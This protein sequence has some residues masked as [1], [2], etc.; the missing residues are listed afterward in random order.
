MRHMAV[1]KKAK[2]DRN[3]NASNWLFSQTTGVEILHAWS[4]QT[5]LTWGCSNINYP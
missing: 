4:C 1:V 5:A 3:C 2:K